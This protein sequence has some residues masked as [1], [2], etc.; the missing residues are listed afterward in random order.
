MPSAPHDP[1][2]APAAAPPAPARLPLHRLAWAVMLGLLP[3]LGL[4][5]MLARLPQ[6]GIDWALTAD[7]GLALGEAS[8]AAAL[9]GEAGYSVVAVAADADP[10]QPVSA[11][12]RLPSAR[13]LPEDAARQAW[14]ETQRRLAPLGQATTLRLVLADGRELPVAAPRGLQLG[15]APLLLAAL[16]LLLHSLAAW[17]LIRRPQ[18]SSGVFALLAGC[19][20]G[21]LLFILVGQAVPLGLPAA[22]ARAE[23]PLRTALDLA[24]GAGTLHAALLHPVRHPWAGRLAALGWLAAAALLAGLLQ[25]GLDAAW[26]WTQGAV[27]GYGALAWLALGQ[28]G[29]QGHHPQALLLRRLL[30]L[31]LGAWLLLSVAVMASGPGLAAQQV[32]G[33]GS[34]LWTI[35]LAS[36]LVLLPFLR[37]R[38]RLLHEFSLLAGA[39]T[40][41]AS[42]DLLFIA[43]SPG[44]AGRSTGL[45]AFFGVVAYLL[46]RSW[47]LDR[48]RGPRLER[49]ERLFEAIYRSART[50]ERQPQAMPRLLAGLLQGVFDPLQSRCLGPQAGR[51]V[52][53]LL[54]DHGAGLAVPLPRLAAGEPG[55]WVELRLAERGRR[56]F[57]REDARLA[58]LIGEQLGRAIAHDRA[59]ERGRREER[60]RIAQDLHDDI[61]AR[62]LTLMYGAGSAE[63]E[64]YIRHTLQDLKTLTRGLA[65]GSPR[66]GEA[67]ADWKADAEHRLQV[68]GLRLH[69]QQQLGPD[70]ALS[71]AAWSALTRVL[72]ELLSNVLAHARARTVRV[73][74]DCSDGLLQLAV[75]DDG[76]GRDPAGWAHG[77]GLGGIRKRVR[78]LEGQVVWQPGEDGGIVC[79][80]RLP[81]ARLRETGAGEAPDEPTG[82]P[83]DAPFGRTDPASPT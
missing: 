58:D 28:R 38:Q 25:P 52:R 59:V 61:G 35:F 44:A 74:L 4:L 32:A 43:L 13:W 18:A 1:A 73:R 64:D 27:G 36:L 83:D 23:L 20:I 65:A 10:P 41:A 50:A 17:V 66:L 56:I 71:V 42:L 22:W 21:Q 53:S 16:I 62:L 8:T 37:E 24:A 29:P 46:G 40:V 15:A 75:A 45:A 9:R 33:L 63:R 69:W 54:L 60:Q 39:G 70:P 78:Q 68:A 48:L 67:A 31:V 47:L 51:P 30:S 82:G 19:V 49:T 12:W 6:P 14:T 72:R 57:T 3:L 55:G 80:V 2:A 81:L 76:E 77:L 11:L 79:Q 26:R 7:G 5:L 34:T